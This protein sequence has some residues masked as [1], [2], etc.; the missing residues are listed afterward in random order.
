MSLVA[1][2]FWLRQT[3]S[4]LAVA[5]SP[6]SVNIQVSSSNGGARAPAAVVKP[7]ESRRH[8]PTIKRLHNRCR[9][10]SLAQTVDARIG[11]LVHNVSAAAVLVVLAVVG[12]YVA[13]QLARRRVL[14]LANMKRLESITPQ[15]STRWLHLP[16]T[17]LTAAGRPAHHVNAVA[18]HSVAGIFIIR[19]R[20]G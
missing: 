16:G 7:P 4:S 3:S 6:F 1:S 2:T 9:S 20:P 13:A 18:G 8:R 11:R 10:V 17:L 15:R 19:R 12:F 5:V 14:R